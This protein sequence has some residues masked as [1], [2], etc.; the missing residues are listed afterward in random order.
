M[1]QDIRTA[2]AKERF[3]EHG[4]GGGKIIL[5]WISG[6]QAVRMISECSWY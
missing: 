3:V 2:F 5:R 4:K 1:K 6:K